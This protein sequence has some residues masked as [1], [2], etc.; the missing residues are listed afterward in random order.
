M[1]YT[2]KTKKIEEISENK[3]YHPTI[4]SLGFIF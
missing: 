4:T 3:N 2:K 1:I